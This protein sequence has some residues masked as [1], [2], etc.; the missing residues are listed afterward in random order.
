MSS[1]NCMIKAFAIQIYLTKFYSKQL[2][3]QDLPLKINYRNFG[4]YNKEGSELRVKLS[5]PHIKEALEFQDILNYL[6]PF[7]VTNYEEASLSTVDRIM[8][9]RQKETHKKGVY[10]INFETGIEIIMFIKS[11]SAKFEFIKKYLTKHPEKKQLLNSFYKLDSIYGKTEDLYLL[12][13]SYDLDGK[14]LT[15]EYCALQ[16]QLFW[17]DWLLEK[18]TVKPIDGIP[19][20]P[21][22]ISLNRRSI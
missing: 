2:D 17:I 4:A 19:L 8:G 7:Q 3:L 11:T 10:K 6:D 21:V 12:L 5:S 15:P 1:A 13:A 18:Y 20:I 22:F 16:K 9:V 14:I